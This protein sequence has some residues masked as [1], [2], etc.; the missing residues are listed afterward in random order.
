[1]SRI[2]P[3]HEVLSLFGI[4]SATKALNNQ[5]ASNRLLVSLVSAFF[6]VLAVSLLL[7][8]STRLVGDQP[9]P[10]AAWQAPQQA[11]YLPGQFVSDQL[12]QGYLP[13]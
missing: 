7:S 8:L 10:A 12:R 5:A 3:G 2:H 11:A 6:I 13:L 4:A 1:M 9:A